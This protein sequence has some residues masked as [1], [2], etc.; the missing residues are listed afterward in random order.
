MELNTSTAESAENA[1]RELKTKMQKL[2]YQIENYRIR[3]IVNG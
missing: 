3:F 2:K 1:E